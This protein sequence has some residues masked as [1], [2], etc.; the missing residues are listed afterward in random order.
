MIS[1]GIDILSPEDANQDLLATYGVIFPIYASHLKKDKENILVEGLLHYTKANEDWATKE[2]HR[3]ITHYL[4]SFGI[5]MTGIDPYKVAHG[6]HQLLLFLIEDKNVF[7]ILKTV[8]EQ[9]NNDKD[10][11]SKLQEDAK[12]TIYTATFFTMNFILATEEKALASNNYNKIKEIIEHGVMDYFLP[13]RTLYYIYRNAGD[14]IEIDSQ[15]QSDS[16][17][18]SKQKKI[19]SYAKNNIVIDSNCTTNKLSL[20]IIDICKR[21]IKRLNK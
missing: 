10:M 12:K 6:I 2:V 4:D 8:D 21:I 3:M 20:M 18:T 14:V 1:G 7:S 11:I 13:N 17:L 15:Y 19:I 9:H 5:R 16:H